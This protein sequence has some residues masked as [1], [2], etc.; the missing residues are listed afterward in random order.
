MGEEGGREYRGTRTE[1]GEEGLAG[2][3]KDDLPAGSLQRLDGLIVG[4]IPE[5]DAVNGEDGVA[6]TERPAPFRRQP[7]EDTRDEHRHTIL[8]TSLDADTEPSRLRLHH[9]HPPHAT[10]RRLRVAVNHAVKHRRLA[11]SRF[12][13]QAQRFAAQ[14]RRYPHPT[15]P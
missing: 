5:I 10:G 12:R 9:P 4:G 15:F 8:P 13:R 3:F 6:Q 14:F 11:A 7:R 1:D 2:T